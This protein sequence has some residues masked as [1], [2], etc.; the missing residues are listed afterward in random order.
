MVPTP[1]R[2]LQEGDVVKGNETALRRVRAA[3]IAR[4]DVRRPKRPGI[5]NLYAWAR[6]PS[7]FM[8]SRLAAA[9]AEQKDRLDARTGLVRDGRRIRNGW[10]SEIRRMLEQA[11]LCLEDDR[12]LEGWQ[13]VYDVRRA[14]IDAYTPDTLRAYRV[15]LREEARDAL[16][17]GR[18]RA[19][20]NLLGH[21]DQ[22]DTPCPAR[23]DE[24]P[25]R[26]S[27]AREE[28]RMAR[29][30]I[31]G[32]HQGLYMRASH[33][34]T[35]LFFLPIV[36]GLILAALLT[37]SFTVGSPFGADRDTV[38]GHGGSLL[39]IYSLGALGALLSVTLGA[40]RG[41]TRHNYLLL[42]EFRLNVTRCLLGAASAAAVVAILETDLFNVGT[43]GADSALVLAVAIAAGFSE[44]LLTNA[45]SAVV[46]ANGP[47]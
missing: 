16:S 3:D 13:S 21:R 9:I 10:S 28:L 5:V 30:I 31:D 15:A 29:T 46:Q 6:R 39:W 41:L 14:M 23:R 25:E 1:W 32:Q 2:R 8:R 4:V 34:R 35:Q 44:R 22:D 11:R 47:K 18:L 36:L 37:V 38:L 12:L 19:V 33:A 7:V 17:G 26:V 27:K 43:V 45:I 40:I 42:T 24:K 20:E